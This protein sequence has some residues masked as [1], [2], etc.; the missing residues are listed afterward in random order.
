MILGRVLQKRQGA[1]CKIR[2]NKQNADHGDKPPSNTY[3]APAADNVVARVWI[4]RLQQVWDTQLPSRLSWTITVLVAGSSIVF[5]NPRH[6]TPV[7]NAICLPNMALLAA[8]N[9]KRVPS[10]T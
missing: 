9:V 5:R 6:G 8:D 2:R 3:I 10:T 7:A 1:A 4:Q